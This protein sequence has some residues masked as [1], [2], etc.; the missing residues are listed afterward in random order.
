[1]VH[2]PLPTATQN[3]VGLGLRLPGGTKDTRRAS[4]ELICGDFGLITR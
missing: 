3:Y 4:Y 2:G 1:M